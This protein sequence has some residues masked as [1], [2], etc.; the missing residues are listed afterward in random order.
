M[1]KTSE[2][3]NQFMETYRQFIGEYEKFLQN[4]GHSSRLITAIKTST[5]QKTEVAVL[6]DKALQAHIDATN[7][8]I[9]TVAIYRQLV[10]KW[11]VMAKS[12]HKGE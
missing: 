6:Y 5:P 4:Y 10:Q 1:H 12:C 3:Y 2:E 8:Y 11:L 7:T 9:K